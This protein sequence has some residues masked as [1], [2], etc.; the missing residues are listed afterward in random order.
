MHLEAHA[1][2]AREANVN[3]VLILENGD[4]ATLDETGI[5][6]G[7]TVTQGAVATAFGV[8]LDE[9]VLRE[10]AHLGRGG[11]VVVT[12]M[13][14]DDQPT[15]LAVSHGTPNRED[16][17]E[18]ATRAA[19]RALESCPPEDRGVALEE[20]VR[21]AVRRHTGTLLGYRPVVIVRLTGG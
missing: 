19:K 2:L 7:E 15:L 1:A 13:R 20:R 5:R 4:T 16:V 6:R 21:R 11:V 12:I 14:D 10:R 18:A 3:D 17:D 8:E 9:D